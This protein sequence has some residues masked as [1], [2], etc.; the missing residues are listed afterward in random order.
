MNPP[1]YEFLRKILKDSSGLDLSADKQYLIDSRLLPL[2]R[3]AGLPGIGE[4]VQTHERRL[5]RHDSSGR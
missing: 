1:D 3:K 5:R 2:A 4:L